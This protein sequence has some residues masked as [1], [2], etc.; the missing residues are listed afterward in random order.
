MVSLYWCVALTAA[1]AC[2]PPT[3]AQR[4][5]LEPIRLDPTGGIFGAIGESSGGDIS[6][7]D[8]LDIGLERAQA[9]KE[10]DTPPIVAFHPGDIS[11]GVVGI[12]ASPPVAASPPPAPDQAGQ[13][14][15]SFR[16]AEPE[17]KK[18]AECTGRIILE[19]SK[20]LVQRNRIPPSKVS[21]VLARQSVGLPPEECQ[22]RVEKLAG[23]DLVE[24]P[25]P[26]CSPGFPYR[27]IDGSCNNLANPKWGAAM[28]P[29]RRFLD[30]AYE[31][32]V[33]AM[34]GS[35][36]LFGAKLPS[37]RAVSA[38]L[39]K[40][41]QR[42]QR[43]LITLMVMQWGQ[44]TDHDIVH[45]PEAALVESGKDGEA[46]K[47]VE[48][49]ESGRDIPF[50]DGVSDCQPIDVSEDPL[51]SEFNRACMKFVRSLI[52][53]QGCVLGPREQLNQITAYLD[54]SAV[55]GSRDA[56]AEE[57]RAHSG[58]RL[59]WTNSP[60]PGRGHLMPFVECEGGEGGASGGHCFKAGDLRS[61]EQPALASMHTLWVREHNAVAAQLSLVNPHWNDDT[62][63]EE[64]RRIVVALIQQITY[65]DFLP[66]VLGNTMMKKFDLYPLTSGLRDTYNASEDASVLNVFGT[67]AYRFGH[68]LVDDMLQGEGSAV[69]LVGNFFNPE[70]LFRGE[71]RPS[72]LLEGLATMNAQPADAYLVPSLTNN[73]FKGHND[74]VGMD[75][76]ALNIQRG[77]DHGL[78]PYTEWREA[79]GHPPV[80]SFADLV[81]LMSPSV[82]E[83]FEKLYPNVDE[84]DLFPAGLGEKP[85]PDGLLG[86][87]F[88]CIIA[89]QFARLKRGDRFWYEN[90]NQPKPFTED[91][92]DSLREITLSSVI[93]QNTILEHLQPNSFFSAN[94]P[95]N[96]PRPCASY[97]VLKAELW[98]E[99]GTG[100]SSTSSPTT[101]S[102]GSSTPLRTSP[103]STTAS[104]GSTTPLMTT[105]FATTSSSKPTP[106]PGSDTRRSGFRLYQTPHK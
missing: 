4:F 10:K 82:V 34:R 74:P 42:P 61:N 6:V 63:Y 43:G 52:A 86:P 25:T 8:A 56:V 104:G 89:H 97:P 71:S 39:Q 45:T 95:S 9:L 38:M 54:G 41:E 53:N 103:S 100:S 32:G 33:D 87:T 105:P 67:A 23:C 13:L 60:A 36:R 31:D 102:A 93:C 12:Q 92:L 35:D 20:T 72:A 94:A 18:E 57:L 81:P 76:M 88:T 29:F 40:S 3:D 83:G 96:R 69:P 66:I 62:L 99:G 80:S 2:C 17:A 58:G 21:R 59:N 85:V 79:C 11:G 30:P 26:S 73:L 15:F 51:Y 5:S 16:R 50:A 28:I 64:A 48:C 98:R 78:P 68:T 65:R 90:R 24:P 91:Q 49:C 47:P 44:F 19:A 7:L 84:I 46:T 27:S 101:S 22:R 37:P 77:R 1:W 75:L 70:P 55:Y 106:R 14:L